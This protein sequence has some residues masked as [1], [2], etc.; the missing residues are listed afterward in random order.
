[1]SIATESGNSL[2][3]TNISIK[4]AANNVRNRIHQSAIKSQA[5]TIQ[6]HFNPDC[7]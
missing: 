4:E 1:M 7:R 6:K 5:G 2:K 3:E